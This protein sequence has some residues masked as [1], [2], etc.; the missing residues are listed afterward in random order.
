M[1]ISA[2]FVSGAA[3]SKHPRGELEEDTIIKGIYPTFCL[4]GIVF[5]FTEATILI[6]GDTHNFPK[7]T[8]FCTC[9]LLA[10]YVSNT[11]LA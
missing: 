11:R 4:L 2:R 3:L 8:K 5:L 10:S 6:N 1:V 7:S 9:K